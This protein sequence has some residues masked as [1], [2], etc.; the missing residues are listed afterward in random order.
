V[1][2]QVKRLREKGEKELGGKKH[3][4]GQ[5]RRGSKTL[6]KPYPTGNMGTQSRNSVKQDRDYHS[7]NPPS[8]IHRKGGEREKIP[9][10]DGSSLCMLCCASLT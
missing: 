2:T 6:G 4:Y 7:Q 3:Q 10:A 8:E 5:E 9:F 1:E